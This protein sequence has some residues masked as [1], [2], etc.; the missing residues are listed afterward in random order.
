MSRSP[1]FDQGISRKLIELSESPTVRYLREAE[2]NPAMQAA[3]FLEQSDFQKLALSVIQTRQAFDAY[4]RSDQWAGLSVA[5]ARFHADVRRPET[6][7]A[8]EEIEKNLKTIALTAHEGIRPLAASI[9]TFSE[10]AARAVTPLKEHFARVD[11]WQTSLA[12][13]MAGLTTPWA[14]EDHLGVSMVGFA[15]IARLHDL[16]VGGS[17]FG[18][19]TS[20][21]VD[22]ELGEPVPYDAEATL[23]DR[24]AAR[25][26]AGLNPEIVAFP[27]SVYPGVLFSAGFE[28]RIKAIDPVRS[29]R[30]DE[31]GIFD[32]QHAGLFS[33]I[34]NRLRELIEAELSRLAGNS[35]Q[36][37]IHGDV[38]K[39]WKERKTKDHEQRGDSYPLLF[40]A[41]FMELAD[42]I[43]QGDNWKEAFQQFF[44][45]QQDFQVSMQRLAPVRNAIGHN[46]PLV[47]ADQVTLFSEAFRILSALG[48]R[49]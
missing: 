40:Y 2:N 38:R 45:S 30:G 42:V 4:T 15:R 21:I 3:R 39:K 28:L 6:L 27:S 19:A 14:I 7:V 33:Q 5:I 36:R 1:F 10:T 41:D 24:E 23:E 37:R 9:Q 43:C 25:I 11:L 46:R 17:P 44:T 20:E 31:S 29:E 49:L 8:I 34:E 18:P 32:A 48:V 35:W 22:E 26:D 12:E 47:R 16:S 13:R